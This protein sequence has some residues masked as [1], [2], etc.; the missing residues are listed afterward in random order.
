MKR[1]NYYN[2]ML[3]Y[4]CASDIDDQDFD[5]KCKMILLK[6]I[7]IIGT[8]LLVFF[9][10]DAFMKDKY[11]LCS[12][13]SVTAC[14]I[15]GIFIFLRKTK[16]YK[17]AAYL[18]VLIIGILYEYLFITGGLNNTGHLWSFSFPLFTIFLLG[19]TMGSI[20]TFSFFIIPLIVLFNSGLP[21]IHNE[22]QID[23]K[24]RFIGAFFVVYVFTFFYEFVKAKTQEKI[25]LQNIEL[26]VALKDLKQTDG[27]FLRARDELEIKI[28][29]RTRE[30]SDSNKELKTAIDR[31]SW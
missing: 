22:Y 6:I 21:F 16:D 3:W 12:F 7:S 20:A 28:E 17:I 27:E 14:V 24:L 25:K 11:I 26:E 19:P 2:K 23:F 5:V 4:L 15:F 31:Y 13:D 18:D 29:E 9:G 1:I 10:I 30:L 8:F